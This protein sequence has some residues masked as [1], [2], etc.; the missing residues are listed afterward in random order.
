[1]IMPSLNRRQFGH[2]AAGLWPVLMLPGC[3]NETAD[4]TLDEVIDRHTKARGGKARLD[5]V[6]A[7]AVDMRIIE[8]G[9][10]IE[11]RYRCDKSPAYR[12]DIY[13]KG[14][15]VFCEGLDRQGT[16]IWPGDQPGPRQGVE[17]GKRS[18][19][20]GIQFNLYGLHAFPSLGNRLSL[21]GRER[22]AG[23]NFYVV[24]VDLKYG[25]P[26]FL[27]I[28]P[29]TWMIARRREVRAFHPDMDDT[30]RHLETQYSDFREVGGIQN[31]FLQHQV[32]LAGGAITQ[33]IV[34]EKMTYDP[35]LRPDEFNREFTPD[36]V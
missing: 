27:Y 18:G 20:E 9:Q 11:A 25:D 6:K 29:E 23:V 8:K 35:A 22:I 26:T 31:A 13:D 32:D 16:W 36:P 15:H 12:I 2:L 21:D 7:Q 19:L 34:I 10:V 17:D 28:D 14:R 3:S 5:A 30:K 24:R 33:V 4:L 1:M